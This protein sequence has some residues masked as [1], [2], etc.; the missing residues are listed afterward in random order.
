MNQPIKRKK[1]MNKRGNTMIKKLWKIICSPW[2]KFIN[3][4]A[5]G[6]PSKNDKV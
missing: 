3:W 2:I 1:H 5:K 6:L 4:L